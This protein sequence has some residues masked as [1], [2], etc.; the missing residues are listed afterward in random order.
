MRDIETMTTDE[1][2]A[3]R[4]EQLDAYQAKGLQLI[5]DPACSTCD[6]INNY[7]CFEC[8][9]IQLNKGQP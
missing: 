3:H 1:W 9:L 5:P 7:V 2:L 4:A 6:E 8:E